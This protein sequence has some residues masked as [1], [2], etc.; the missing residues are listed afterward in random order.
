MSDD[1]KDL[2]NNFND[3]VSDS[4]AAAEASETPEGDDRSTTSDSIIAALQNLS[5]LET[6]NSE[7]DLSSVAPEIPVEP[8][9]VAPTVSAP[10]ITPTVPVPPIAPEPIAE[11]APTVPVAPIEPVEPLA[12]VESVNPTESLSPVEQV[13]P[14]TPIELDEPEKKKPI[15]WIIITVLASII[16]IVAA[17]FAYMTF[18]APNFKEK[19]I[20]I[21]A[22]TFSPIKP[23]NDSNLVKAIPLTVMNLGLIDEEITSS[24]ESLSPKYQYHMVYSSAKDTSGI[25]VDTLLGQFLSKAKAEEAY[26][27][28]VSSIGGTQVAMFPVTV[29][30]ETKGTMVLLQDPTNPDANYAIWQNDS[31]V[32]KA[33]GPKN[34]MLNFYNAYAL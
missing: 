3:K 16:I 13:E 10:P 33:Y 2:L 5:E 30:N 27:N 23:I 31:V 14:V 20:E 22:P 18:I 8:A 17:I 29:N 15:K 7:N 4:P 25:I 32:I 1:L 11:P 24:L 6:N 26:N 28:L 9:P 19:Q 34:V 21:T 12:P